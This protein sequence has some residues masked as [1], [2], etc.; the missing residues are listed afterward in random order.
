MI[1][2]FCLGKIKKQQQQQQQKKKRTPQTLSNSQ[3]CQKE[4][5]TINRLWYHMAIF[6]LY[7]ISAED[8]R[9]DMGVSGWYGVWYENCHIIISI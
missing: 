6:I 2:L 4:K 5:C 1:R 9:A 7:P 3:T 8:P